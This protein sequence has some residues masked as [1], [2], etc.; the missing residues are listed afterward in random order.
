MHKTHGTRVSKIELWIQKQLINK[1][2]T[3]EFHFNKKDTINGELDIYVP[4][5]NLAFEIN[6]IY[7]YQPIHG[8]DKLNKIKLNDQKKIDECQ[9]RNINL[10]TIDVSKVC[11]FKPQLVQKYLD[12]IIF[13]ISKK[14]L[15]IQS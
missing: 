8:N 7:H 4:C 15:D 10:V 1:Y 13:E 2:S 9:R 14:M 6:G 11:Y 3:L 5:L 12:I